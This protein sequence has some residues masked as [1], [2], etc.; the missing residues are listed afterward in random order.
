M[1]A[2]S[3]CLQNFG[4]QVLDLLLRLPLLHVLGVAAL[5]EVHLS[6]ELIDGLVLI[7]LGAAD[8]GGVVRHWLSDNEVTIARFSAD[9]GLILVFF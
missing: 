3:G 7:A 2:R 4:E 1:L 5:A 6:V 9:P 8:D